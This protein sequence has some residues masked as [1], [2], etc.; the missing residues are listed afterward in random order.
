M[1]KLIKI[2]A[3]IAVAAPFAPAVPAEADYS[4]TEFLR[5]L[6][7][8][9]IWYTDPQE[10]IN[11]AHGVCGEMARGMRRVDIADLVLRDHP[12]FSNWE[13]ADWFVIIANDS[14]CPW[15]QP[16][17]PGPGDLGGGPE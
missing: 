6:Q 4:D 16:P 10:V 11:Y 1:S 5:D 9:G 13:N 12:K 2:A 8:H 15:L 7:Q 3:L 17:T 14:Y